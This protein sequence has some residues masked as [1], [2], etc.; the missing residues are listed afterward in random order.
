MV[1]VDWNQ[2]LGVIGESE[3]QKRLSYFSNVGK[4]E[5]DVG[6]DFVCDLLDNSS[7][8]EPFYVQAKGTQHFDN[9]WGASV[10]KSTI[11]LW[12]S[13]MS[14][15]YLI[16]YDEIEKE[17]Y[18]NSIEDRRYELIEKMD[19]PNDTIYISVDRS[20][21]LEDGK[22]M[23]DE[24]INK[25]RIDYSSIGLWYGR[26]IPIGREYVKLMPGPPRSKVELIRTRSNLR[27]NVSS[28][29]QHYMRIEELPQALVYADFLSKIDISHYDHFFMLGRIYVKLGRKKDARKSYEEALNICERDK[30]WP[31]EDMDKLKEMIRKEMEIYAPLN[32]NE[33]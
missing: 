26:P 20:H 33:T 16:V 1:N 29:I 4:Y 15:V 23:N 2:R 5:I 14:P 9:G 24:F 10:K 21:V 12:L 31:K 7:P 22:D 17:C 11:F 8:A 25:I 13:R 28:L 32:E 6:I 27:M 30:K 18:W 19:S 3:I